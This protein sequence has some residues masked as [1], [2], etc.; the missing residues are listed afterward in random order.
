MRNRTDWSSYILDQWQLTKGYFRLMSS[1]KEMQYTRRFLHAAHTF[2]RFVGFPS[3]VRWNILHVVNHLEGDFR[4]TMSYLLSLSVAN[5]GNIC[6]YMKLWHKT[7]GN[8]KQGI[9]FID[10]ALKFVLIRLNFSA[11]KH[12][13]ILWRISRN[14][15][16]FISVYSA[17]G[18]LWMCCKQADICTHDEATWYS[19]I[20]MHFNIIQPC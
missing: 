8:I 3:L 12:D 13:S 6:L 5:C 2:L 20:V 10:I 14:T 11:R 1:I 9:I 18:D 15:V 17:E 19:C 16:N 7:P 4:I